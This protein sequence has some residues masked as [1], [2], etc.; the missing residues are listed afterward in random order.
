MSKNK[1][2]FME[3]KAI[4]DDIDNFFAT[5]EKIP[6]RL[7]YALNKNKHI[8]KDELDTMK[9]KFTEGVKELQK[10]QEE[11][12]QKLEECGATKKMNAQGNTYLTDMDKVD[13]EHYEKEVEK[14]DKKYK[15]SLDKQDKINEENN[16]MATEK[17]AEVDFYTIDFELF[18]DEINP[19]VFTDNI[20][21][22]IK[23]NE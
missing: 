11:I 13:V 2:S 17:V 7:A 6:F 15:D 10:Y 1:Y 5:E 20:A 18:P 22:L 14:L 3:L 16:K 9:E 19:K 8:I 21:L 23:D 12:H 4:K